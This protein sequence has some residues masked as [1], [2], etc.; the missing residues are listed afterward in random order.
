MRSPDDEKTSTVGMGENLSQLMMIRPP[1]VPQMVLRGQLQEERVTGVASGW[2][3]EEVS[4]KTKE[5][6]W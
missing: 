3:I 6:E 4:E 5:Y 2:S 1:L